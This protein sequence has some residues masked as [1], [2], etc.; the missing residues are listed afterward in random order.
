MF[1]ARRE[2]LELVIRPALAPRRLGGVRS[3]HRRHLRLSGRR[4]WRAVR[5][6]SRAR[7]VDSRGLPTRRHV[8]VRR[9]DRR[10]ARAARFGGARGSCPRQVRAGGERVFRARC[11]TRT[12][13]VPRRCRSAFASSTARGRWT[14]CAPSSRRT[15]RR[16]DFP[17]ER[18][19]AVPRRELRPL[20]GVGRS[21]GVPVTIE[22][23]ADPGGLPWLPL[24]PWQHDAARAALARRASWP[25]ALLIHGP[26][27]IGKHALRAQSRAR[28]AVRNTTDGR[29]RLRHVRRVPLCRCRPAP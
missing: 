29:A 14:S 25:H 20:G 21:G 19:R 11:A 5:A 8:S 23:T 9:A 2:H 27:G 17:R 7:A 18:R 28:V 26:R 10:F 3:L 1:A 13:S 22:R 6:H 15:W 16:W 24:L 12:S 4:A